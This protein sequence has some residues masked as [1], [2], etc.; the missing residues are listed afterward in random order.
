[1][2]SPWCRSPCR[3]SRIAR[4]TAGDALAHA[5]AYGLA[6]VLTFT[7]VGV[8]IALAFGAS[9]LN[10]FAADPWLNL[11]VTALFVLFALSLF[12]V[13]ELALPSRLI[14]VAAG[15]GMGHR[16]FASTML[17]G[18]A[19]TLTSFTCTAPFLGTLFVVAS[20]GDWQW[21]LVGM[22]AF[23]MVFALPFVVLALAPQL[24]A[25]L[26][27]SGLWLVAVKSVMGLLE[28]AAAMKF[29]SNADLVWGWNIFTRPVVIASWIA[30]AAVLTAY[31]AGVIRLGPA[32]RLGRPGPA[33]VAASAGCALL[34]LW[35]ASGLS[36][37]RLG[38]A[39]CLSAAR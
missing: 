35:L 20:Q 10:R 1:M 5:V 26:P 30:I 24:L 9:G 38:R 36:G 6:I 37:R 22:L 23:S 15:G 11:A 19:F 3:S 31:L 18:L 8:A 34:G 27:R 29:L 14:S 12:G 4:A 16:R 17:M 28:L 33:R 2:C 21:P 32:P 39:G 7:A 13:Y 25:A